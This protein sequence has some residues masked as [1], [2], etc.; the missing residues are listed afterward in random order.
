MHNCKQNLP[1]NQ[2]IC[3]IFLIR[4]PDIVLPSHLHPANKKYGNTHQKDENSIEYQCFMHIE[5]RI[6]GG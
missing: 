6:C 2:E 5:R 1:L 4:H 3:L